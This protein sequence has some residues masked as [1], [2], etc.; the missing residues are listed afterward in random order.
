M[1]TVVQDNLILIVVALLIGLGVALWA[2]RRS[3]SGADLPDRRT[4]GPERNGLQDEFAAATQDVAGEILGVDA[5]PAIPGPSGPPDNLRLLKGV[6]PKMA[7]Q[8][9]E[10]GITRFDQLAG[11]TE[12]EVALLDKRMG[13]FE[14]RIARDRL[15]EQA[16]YLERGDKD[17][18]EAKFGKLGGA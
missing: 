18:F 6:G 4:D 14:G 15:V 17:G 11:L 8:L 16:C 2:F 3:G 7:A 10:F 9:N 1:W 5:H 12:T 13:A